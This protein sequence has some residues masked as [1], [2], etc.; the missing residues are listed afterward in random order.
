[1]FSGRHTPRAPF[2]LYTASTSGS[3][4]TRLTTAGGRQPAPCENGSIAFVHR[5]DVYLLSPDHRTLR[6][7]TRRGGDSPDGRWI[8]FV[9]HGDLYVMPSAGGRLRRLTIHHL[10][11]GRPGF[12]PTGR[13]LAF[14][15]SRRC[16]GGESCCSLTNPIPTDC[17][18]GFDLAVVDLRGHLRR[19]SESAAA[20]ST[21]MAMA[22]AISVMSPG[23]RYRRLAAPALGP[24]SAP[25]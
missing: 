25:L 18:L 16:R 1:M 23:S 14:T 24:G 11:D 20:A 21:P 10:L 9:R 17:T 15:T 19:K 3:N 13:Q 5:H 8:A 12:S 22:D 2:D 4:L 7:L 6:R